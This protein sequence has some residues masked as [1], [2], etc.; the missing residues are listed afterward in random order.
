V[1]INHSPFSAERREATHK[2]DNA[3]NKKLI[4]FLLVVVLLLSMACVVGSNNLDAMSQ[5]VTPLSAIV[6]GTATARAEGDTGSSDELATAIA[7]ATAQS[8]V[9]YATQTARASLSDE[10]RLATA[11][12]I[13][14]VVA[15]LPLFGIDPA[16]GH[17]AWL[18]NPVT[19]DLNGYHQFG[20][21]NDYQQITA[22]DFVLASD[23]TWDTQYGS[24]GCGFM[25]RSDGDKNKPNQ[26]MVF[27]T[28]FSN[29][30]LAFS[31]TV[32]GDISNIHTFYPSQEDKSFKW[33]NKTTNRLAVVARGPI[34]E[35]YT[36]GVKVGEVD[37]TKPP[38]DNMKPPSKPLLPPGANAQQITDYQA[39][40]DQ[41]SDITNQMTS[42]LNQAKQNYAKNKAIFSDGFLGFLGL[43]ESGH[44]SC[45]F[46]DAWLFIIE[47]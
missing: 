29:G 21:A 26:Y 22:K 16:Q 1:T 24:S 4:P 18:H 5:T 33:F 23:I 10:S 13:A 20:Y 17:V 12:V 7:K 28:R 38:P 27:I 14:P 44:T 36:N 43:S 40:M 25:F 2:R 3:M 6:E 9:I 15:E 37:T 8:Q 30:A 34:I 47:Q 31:A 39:Q 45:T 19:I 41:Y 11:T 46:E 35:I 42:Q 32:N